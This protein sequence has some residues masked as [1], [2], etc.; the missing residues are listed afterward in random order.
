MEGR[1]GVAPEERLRRSERP[2]RMGAVDG[3]GLKRVSRRCDGGILRSDRGGRWPMRSSATPIGVPRT[4]SRKPQQACEIHNWGG[5]TRTTNFLINSQAV[6][7]LT[8]APND[9]RKL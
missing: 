1:T 5:W 6:C 4:R 9:L 2:R 7:Q 8:Y 3:A